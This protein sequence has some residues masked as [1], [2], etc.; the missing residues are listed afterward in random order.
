MGENQ[1]FTVEDI[2]DLLKEYKVVKQ[3]ADAVLSDL[4]PDEE[5][6]ITT[7]EYTEAVTVIHRYQNT[8]ESLLP[9]LEKH[10]KE[11]AERRAKNGGKP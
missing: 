11:K 5:G 7:G 4:Q 9:V 6:N 8:R 10:R 3:L 1:G 2:R